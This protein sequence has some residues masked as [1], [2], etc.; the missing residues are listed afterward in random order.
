MKTDTSALRTNRRVVYTAVFGNYDEVSPV[1]S[2]TGLDFLCFTDNPNAQPGGWR[3]VLVPT[4]PAG[5]ALQNRHHKMLAHQHLAGYEES[6]YIDGH[7]ILKQCPVVLFDKYLSAGSLAMPGHPDRHCAYEEARYCLADG[8][9]QAGVI[10]QQMAD[11]EGAGFP[12][13]QGLTENG[14]ILRRHHEPAV[15]QLMEAWWQ[16]YVARARRDQISLPYLAWKQGIT[17][18]L[19]NEGPRVDGRY[20]TL[21]P[22]SQRTRSAMHLW[23]WRLEA[24]KHR[25]WLHRTVHTVYQGLRR[26][27]TGR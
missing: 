17:I 2:C 19:I 14:I 6:L 15:V 21:K 18:S 26:L 11:Y 25:S 27:A 23:L 12:R 20:F 7:V 10:S 16:E 8:K 13:Q 5:P 9:V 3:V 24:F 4:D 1:Q 22:H